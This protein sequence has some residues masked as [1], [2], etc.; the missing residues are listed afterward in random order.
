MAIKIL[1]SA[2]AASA[3]AL[4]HA[5][6]ADVTYTYTGATFNDV[7]VQTWLDPEVPPEV[8]LAQSAAAKA[9][10]LNDH[11]G[12]TLTT[13]VY[14]PTGWSNISYTGIVGELSGPLYALQA[15]YPGA[16]VSWTLTNTA[17]GGSGHIL[18]DNLGSFDPWLESQLTVSLHVGTG[19]VIDAWEI[20]VLPGLAYG[21]PNWDIHVASSSTGGDSLVHEFGAAHYA[22]RREAATTDIGAWAV[23]GSPVAVVP[24]PASYALLLA[25]LALVA[26]AAQRKRA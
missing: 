20:T 18:L 15:D 4:P 2:L 24:E 17:F 13:P 11:I 9:I 26:G 19:N 22:Q 5:A 25:G 1:L 21:A 7:N 16:G 12:I 23:S 14:L 6:M 3:F 8:A 10:L